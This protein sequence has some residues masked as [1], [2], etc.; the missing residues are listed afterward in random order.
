MA[1]AV[2][3]P[4]KLDFLTKLTKINFPA[5]GGPLVLLNANLG[6]TGTGPVS[7]P[8]DGLPFDVDMSKSGI[9][10]PTNQSNVPITDIPSKAMLSKL[11]AWSPSYQSYISAG[12]NQSAGVLPAFSQGSFLLL[13]IGRIAQDFPNWNRKIT[14]D[15]P[16]LTGVVPNPQANITLYIVYQVIFNP[17]NPFT[18]LSSR[19]F[20]V[21][22]DYPTYP[23]S[24]SYITVFQQYLAALA[25]VKGG[26]TTGIALGVPV[27]QGDGASAIA[28]QEYFAANDPLGEA[29]AT[30]QWVLPNPSQGQQ[31]DWQF[32]AGLY[33][34][35]A[36]KFGQ[37]FNQGYLQGTETSSWYTPPPPALD[38]NHANLSP[39]GPVSVVNTGTTVVFG[40]QEP[41][42]DEITVSKQK[43]LSL[44][45]SP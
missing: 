12:G 38:G 31:S 17:P 11:Y 19:W 42:K 10:L 15:P 5:P 33:D 28:A 3:P 41:P 44:S 20:M 23:T 22:G 27:V 36:K 24:P 21:F 40:S 6:E 45:I 37:A 2:Q 18:P 16:G 43:T 4:L 30:Y 13:N 25:G 39:N 1:G 35:T 9:I 29:F 7:L 34:T 26:I 8:L 32:V 14:I